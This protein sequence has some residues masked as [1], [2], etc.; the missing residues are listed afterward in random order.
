[1]RTQREVS[2]MR[3]V[4]RDLHRAG[5]VGHNDLADLHEKTAATTGEM[6][7]L[8]RDVQAGLAEL[9]GRVGSLEGTV[10]ELFANLLQ[11]LMAPLASRIEKLER[12]MGD[13]HT[14]VVGHS[15]G[16]PACHEQTLKGCHA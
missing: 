14:L 13:L 4:V 15:R 1:M 7:L 11:P 2:A 3:H 5:S 12:T 8:N 9:A 10:D 6:V 16:I